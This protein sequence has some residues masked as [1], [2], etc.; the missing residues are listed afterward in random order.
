VRVT[1]SLLAL[2]ATSA[3]LVPLAACGD[4]GE[5]SFGST[6][7]TADVTDETTAEDTTDDSTDDTTDDTTGD[8]DDLGIGDLCLNDEYS[9]A[10]AEVGEAMGNLG[11]G[12]DADYGALEEFFDAFAEEAPDD[13]ADDFRVFADFWGDYAE[14][15]GSIDFSD[16]DTFQDPDVLSAFDDLDT[17]ALDEAS[18]NID[19]WITENC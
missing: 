9:E 14:V 16:P 18:A 5:S 1:R 3:L 7:D 11:S 6:D 2:L 8:G 13:I 4:D 10:M 15:F 17:E 19:A 12:E